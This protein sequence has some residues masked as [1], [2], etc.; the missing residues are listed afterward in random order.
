MQFTISGFFI[1]VV[2]DIKMTKLQTE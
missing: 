1:A 2:S